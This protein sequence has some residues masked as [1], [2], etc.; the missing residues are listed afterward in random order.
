MKCKSVYFASPFPTTIAAQES[1]ASV[2]ALIHRDYTK[3]GA[4][5]IRWEDYG[6]TIS[7]PGGF[8]EGV[9]L[10]NLLVVEPRPRNPFLAD[11]IKT[12]RTRRTN[13]A[14]CR[15]NL[16]GVIALRKIRP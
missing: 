9:S 5:H 11:A 14:R 15:F 6:I 8:V 2:N 3:L 13:W 10:D 7:N 1:E 12:H 16:S 4:V